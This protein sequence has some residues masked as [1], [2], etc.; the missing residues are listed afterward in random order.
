MT[1]LTPPHL[2]PNVQLLQDVR[3][4]GAGKERLI[5][6]R[7]I[8]WAPCFFFSLDFVARTESYIQKQGRYN[9]LSSS[10][11]PSACYVTSFL[12]YPHCFKE[13]R[14]ATKGTMA[15]KVESIFNID[16]CGRL[17]K[18][19]GR[20]PQGAEG[21]SPGLWDALDGKRHESKRGPQQTLKGARC[22]QAS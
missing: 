8:S 2:P 10:A 5:Q 16:P 11:I 9:N 18:G 17:R 14:E 12:F 19:T 4:G 13:T 22:P 3:A 15:L 7:L 6:L 20:A 1:T 21:C